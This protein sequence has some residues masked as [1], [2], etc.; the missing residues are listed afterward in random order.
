M[1]TKITDRY[2]AISIIYMLIYIRIRAIYCWYDT[3]TDILSTNS[4]SCFGE[5]GDVCPR[6]STHHSS[7]IHNLNNARHT[8][9]RRTKNSVYKRME[10]S[11]SGNSCD[12]FSFCKYDRHGR[13]HSLL[14]AHGTSRTIPVFWSAE[15]HAFVPLRIHCLSCLPSLRSS[16]RRLHR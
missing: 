16:H 2:L 14:S 11:H 13:V 10:A 9:R 5:D 7:V 1:H 4:A 15:T 12:S 8:H 3:L 6:S